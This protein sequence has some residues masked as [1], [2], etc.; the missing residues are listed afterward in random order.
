MTDQQLYL[1]IGVPTL[2]VLV[3]ILI[4]VGYF[5]TMNGRF[6]SVEGR[7]QALESRLDGRIHSLVTKF[8]LLI[9]KVF[10]LDNRLTRIEEKLSH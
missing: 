9:G 5:V 7:I 1:S 3:G 2:V 4:N 6:T 8:D 10:E